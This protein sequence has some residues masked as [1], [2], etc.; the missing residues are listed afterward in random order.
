MID[1]KE[2][3][4]VHKGR[5]R[6]FGVLIFSPCTVKK[7]SSLKTFSVILNTFPTGPTKLTMVKLG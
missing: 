4:I 2:I 1:I 7:L 5:G 6:K 3:E